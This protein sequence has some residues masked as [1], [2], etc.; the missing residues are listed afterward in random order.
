VI[1]VNRWAL[2]DPVILGAITLGGCERLL[3]ADM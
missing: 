2:G 3:D 1:V